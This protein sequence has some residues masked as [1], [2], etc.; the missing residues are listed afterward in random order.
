MQSIEINTPIVS[1]L[2]LCKEILFVSVIC[3]KYIKHLWLCADCGCYDGTRKDLELFW[4]YSVLRDVTNH[5][6]GNLAGVMT[7]TCH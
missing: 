1:V 2:Q 4:R 5:G 3:G 6:G 7:K